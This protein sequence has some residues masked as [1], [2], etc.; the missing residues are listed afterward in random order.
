MQPSIGTCENIAQ[1]SKLFLID[2]DFWKNGHIYSTL[3]MLVLR[4]GVPS[5]EHESGSLDI[6]PL[7]RWWA[8][9]I[10]RAMSNVF[11]EMGPKSKQLSYQLQLLGRIRLS[12][13]KIKGI[14]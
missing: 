13:I 4:L 9:M 10:L 5:L 2:D 14:L 12:Y 8:Q 6:F 11:G 1:Q 7:A 3:Y